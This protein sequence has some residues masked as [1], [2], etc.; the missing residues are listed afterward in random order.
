MDLREFPERV[1]VFDIN[2]TLDCGYNPDGKF[3][4]PTQRVFNYLRKHENAWVGTWSGMYTW[5][6]LQNLADA[7]I[8]P[9]FTIQKHEWA[10]FMHSV[11]VIYK[12]PFDCEVICIGDEEEDAKCAEM[13]NMKYYLPCDFWQEYEGKLQNG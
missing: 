6:Q 11:S 1:Y 13:Y 12:K 10:G 5:M 2:G 7:N 9:D 4:L 8:F 3:I